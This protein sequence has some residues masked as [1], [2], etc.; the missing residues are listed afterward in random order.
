[1]V[2]ERR[3]QFGELNE[4]VFVVLSTTLQVVSRPSTSSIL[5][6]SDAIA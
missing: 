2:S 1:M 3:P 4:K 6:F 5:L